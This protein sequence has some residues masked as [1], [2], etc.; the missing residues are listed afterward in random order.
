MGQAGNV[1]LC[2]VRTI[3]DYLALHSHPS[4]VWV[5]LATCSGVRLH[6]LPHLEKRVHL[7]LGSHL[8]TEDAVCTQI[9][10]LVNV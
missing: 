2:V 4:V 8:V 1:S 10:W 6:A 5:Q 7:L 3:A 9:V